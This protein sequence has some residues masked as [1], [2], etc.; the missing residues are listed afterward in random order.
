MKTTIH[1]FFLL[2]FSLCIV[3]CS[4][5]DDNLELTKENGKPSLIETVDGTKI[6]FYYNGDKLSEIKEIKG[7]VITYGYENDALVSLSIAPED[8]EVADGHGFIRFQQMDNSMIRVESSGEPDFRVFKWDITVF[9]GLP[10]KITELGLYSSNPKEAENPIYE[11]EYYADFDYD[12]TTFDLKKLTVYDKKTNTKV[13]TYTYEYDGK[14]G[15]LSK[16]NLPLWYYA[17]KA[18][19]G[20]TYWSG[21]DKII[22][23][24]SNL[25]KE[26]IELADGTETVN[27]TY[28]YNEAGYPIALEHDHS[29]RNL[30]KITY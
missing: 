26:T 15:V 1:L 19:A 7:S 12:P 5:D 16:V 8:K 4:D 3:S 18:Y 13:A 27:W 6:Y 21:Y 23:G 30:I 11:G 9:G 20:K 14:P 17:Y 2:F 28:R 29:D 22:R 25:L 24:G 10:V